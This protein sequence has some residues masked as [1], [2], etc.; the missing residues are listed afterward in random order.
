[1]DEYGYAGKI[2]TVDLTTEKVSHLPTSAYAGRFLGGRGIAA[3]IYWDMVNP[4]TKALDPENCLIFI[5]GPLAG[6][7][8]FA[9]CRW[10]VCGKSPEME[11][12]YFSYANLGGSWGA[13]L[14]YAGYDGL[15][16]T[17]RAAR[18][19]FL[20]IADGDTVEIKDASHLWGQTTVRTEEILQAELGKDART[21]QIGPAG[22]NLVSFATILADDNSSGSSGLGAVMGSKKLKAIVVKAAD[23]KMPRAANPETLELLARQVYELRTGNLEY[24]PHKSLT[25]RLKA[26][27]GCICGCTRRS[28]EAEDHRSYKSFCQATLVYLEHAMKYNRDGTEIYR[29]ATRLCDKYSLDSAVMQPLIQWLGKCYDSGILNDDGTG[30]PLSRIGSAEFIET[31]VHKISFR[32]GFGDVLAQG[33][34]KATQYVGKGSEKLVSTIIATRAGE[35]LDYDP[36]LFLANALIYATEPRR[37]IQLLHAMAFPLIRWLNWRDGLDNAFL[38]T[39]V[40]RN[41]AGKFWGGT[42]GADF[43]TSAGKALAAKNIQ[44]YGYIKESLILCDQAWPIYQVH[45]P[46]KEA[47]GALEGRIL[48]AVTGEKISPAGLLKTG[49]RIFNLQRAILLREGWGGREGDILM[50]FFHEEPLQGVY[51]SPEGLAPDKDGRAVSRKGAVVTREEFEKMKDEYYRL[52]GWDEPS[53]LP[54]RASLEGLGLR[55]ICAELEKAGLLK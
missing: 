22:E 31:L 52:R 41:I 34:L 45:A 13:W 21:L 32:E 18:P 14:K 44:D 37:P 33:I 53:G 35:T 12:E 9:G 43:S 29:M 48:A 26:C 2:L 54:T 4:Q 19:V 55:D 27:Y 36:R 30:L 23:K 6:F 28:Y 3:K 51:F 40:F 25:G 15:V 24:Q 16:V 7:T 49:E 1:M 17:G 50:D 42:A 38:S 11:P 8:R 46:D 10:Q 5:T 20:Y 47:A 39:E